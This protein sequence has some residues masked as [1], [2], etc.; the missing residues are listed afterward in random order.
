MLSKMLK[1]AGFDITVAV[2]NLQRR[3]GKRFP[4]YASFSKRAAGYAAYALAGEPFAPEVR[5]DEP[6]PHSDVPAPA[7]PAHTARV[8]V[9]ERY[10]ICI[11]EPVASIE[12]GFFHLRGWVAWKG[13]LPEV[14]GIVNGKPVLF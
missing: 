11:D 3:A 4:R 14:S 5:A 1:R 2:G 13:E 12:G 8:E 6:E 10:V 7:S 9:T